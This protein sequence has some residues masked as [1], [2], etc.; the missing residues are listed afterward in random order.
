MRFDPELIPGWDGCERITSEM[1]EARR[2]ELLAVLAKEEFGVLPEAP[3]KVDS[4]VLETRKDFECSGHVTMEEIEVSFDAP[5][6]RCA[7][8]YQ[9]VVPNDGK[10]HPAFVYISFTRELYGRY[11]PLEE[12]TEHGF[13]VAV[14]CYTDVTS[15]DADLT[16]R[17]GGMFERP[18]DGTGWGKIGMWAYAASRVIDSLA[19]RTDIDMDRIAVIG[20]SRLGKTALWCGAND[21]RAK[22]VISNDSGCGGAA[23]ERTKHAEAETIAYMSERFPFW[24][25]ENRTGHAGKEQEMPFDQHFLLAAVAP[26]YL[27]VGSASRDLWADPLSEQICCSAAS[28]A[29]EALGMTGY[30]GPRRP[31]KAGEDFSAG[32]IAYHLRDGV[33]CLGRQDWLSY[34]SFIEKRL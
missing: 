18:T 31:A 7:F 26:R 34:L 14:L 9:L 23:Y 24:F 4:R 22:F 25:C 29:W 21:V 33:H 6:G 27:M 2:R 10:K 3:G 8:P 15:D 19:Q 16:D 20:H 17:L 5:K 11:L 30:V 1:W 13:A 12:I 32:D 28:P